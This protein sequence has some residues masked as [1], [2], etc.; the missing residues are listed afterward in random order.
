MG[1]RAPAGEGGDA[2]WTPAF[3]TR[4]VL[5]WSPH[6]RGSGVFWQLRVETPGELS[7]VCIWGTISFPECRLPLPSP[8]MWRAPT[9]L[10]LMG[11]PSFPDVG[12]PSH[13]PRM[14]YPLPLS[15]YGVSLSLPRYEEPFL[16]PEL[17]YPL[18]VPTCVLLFLPLTQFGPCPLLK[19]PPWDARPWDFPGGEGG[20]AWAPSVPLPHQF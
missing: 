18:P 3:T 19:P 2:A 10:S 1:G 8:R 17:G 12:A 7:S 13:L 5:L 11:S 20:W 9:Y 6:R 15:T 14:V 4:S 16:F